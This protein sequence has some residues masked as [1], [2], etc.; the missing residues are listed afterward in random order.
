MGHAAYMRGSQAIRLL[1]K[2][3]KQWPYVVDPVENDFS[4]YYVCCACLY[5]DVSG[6]KGRL[7]F[8]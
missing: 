8:P 7:Y 6:K 2:D 3:W 1:R 4:F 5:R